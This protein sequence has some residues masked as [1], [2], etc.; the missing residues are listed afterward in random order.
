MPR[1]TRRERIAQDLRAD[2]RRRYPT[3]SVEWTPLATRVT[4]PFPVLDDDG[5]ELGCFQLE[6]TCGRR[7][8]HWPPEIRETEGRLPVTNNRHLP[9]SRRGAFCLFSPAHYW[10]HGFDRRPLSDLLDGPVRSFL[11]YQLCVENEVRWQHGERAHSVEGE[12]SFFDELFDTDR[13]GTDRFLRAL[14]LGIRDRACC[15]CGS[16]REV[17]ACHP[18]C[19]RLQHGAA[20]AY[21]QALDRRV[22][23]ASAASSSPAST[24][25]Q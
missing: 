11:L 5:V 21:V 8:P 7:Y 12:L 9:P 6:I 20:R 4:G 10:V 1:P 3:L 18:V 14:R 25:R 16:G 15:P 13:Q 23:T 22:D 2:L 24:Y 19:L 17:R